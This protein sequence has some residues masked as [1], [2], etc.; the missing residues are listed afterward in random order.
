MNGT[1]KAI[2]ISGIRCVQFH[3]ESKLKGEGLLKVFDYSL[4]KAITSVYKEH[5]WLLWKFKHSKVPTGFCSSS[6]SNV[7]IGFWDK[8]ENV[9][10]YLDWLAAQMGIVM[11]GNRFSI[12]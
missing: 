10:L 3:N 8:E 7:V 2:K 12:E 1:T 6:P 4:L 9:K 5:E 11:E